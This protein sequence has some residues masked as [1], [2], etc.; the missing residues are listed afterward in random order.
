[1]TTTC[2]DARALLPARP[3]DGLDGDELHDVE[4]HLA[5][6]SSCRERAGAIDAAFEALR[7]PPASAGASSAKASDDPVWARIAEALDEPAASPAGAPAPA[8]AISIALV[9]SFCRG[10]IARHEAA[11]CASCLA[12][13][14]GEC[15]REHGRCSTFGCEET[16]TV[17]PADSG[18]QASPSRL[19]RLGP[20][21]VVTL[22]LGAGAA[23]VAVVGMQDELFPARAARLREERARR[24]AERAESEAALR[25]ERARYEKLQD[26]TTAG[27]RQLEA[28][29]TQLLDR[30]WAAE[31]QKAELEQAYRALQG[32]IR[33][34]DP[35]ALEKGGVASLLHPA[36][37]AAAIEKRV[38]ELYASIDA[39]VKTQRLTQVIPCL[40]ELER[41]LRE[42]ARLPA[43]ERV[44]GK[45]DAWEKRLGDLKEI[46]QA[47][48]LQLWI[49][50]GNESLAT[51]VEA[52]RSERWDD[53]RAAQRDLHAL[54][55]RMRS[56]PGEEYQ[57][58]AAA[59]ATR[60]NALLE[61]A[62]RLER[63]SK[64]RRGDEPLPARAWV[65][66]KGDGSVEVA[67]DDDTFVLAAD[68]WLAIRGK[69]EPS[70]DGGY[71]GYVVVPEENR[72]VAGWLEL[73]MGGPVRVRTRAGTV[74]FDQAKVKVVFLCEE[75]HFPPQRVARPEESPEPSPPPKKKRRDKGEQ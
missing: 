25:E 51:M 29:K 58:N 33:V 59:L 11:Y 43:R 30:V 70:P 5:S 65:A 28:E 62:T 47:I 15:F 20:G 23:A 69:A 67:L 35:A 16:R 55:L 22:L 40:L 1:M 14:H 44:A 56:Q 63:V 53:L 21:L 18:R 10:A 19:S 26:E 49:S 39:S 66:P 41:L 50:E 73:Q 42:Y 36:L 37:D 61:E 9:C 60:G 2:T 4:E 45:L 57:S 74:A 8:P 38:E 12:P 13:H 52:K 48:Q 6:C 54:F 68:A 72:T 32:E 34:L 71:R 24:E 3:L 7:E 75:P 17:R 64:I 46:R 27:M 31:K